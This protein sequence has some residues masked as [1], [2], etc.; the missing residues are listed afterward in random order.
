MPEKFDDEPPPSRY[1]AHNN[2]ENPPSREHKYSTADMKPENPWKRICCSILTC[3]VCIAIMIAISLLMQELF[4]PS[5]DEDWS[6]DAVNGTG[7][8]DLYVPGELTGTAA[9]LP[10]SMDFI[11]DVCSETRLG[12]DD[13]GACETACKP[14]GD[15]CNPFRSGNSTCF[16]DQPAGCFSYAKCHSLDGFLDPAHN[17][18]DR[19]CSKASIEI[20][21]EECE[22]A[23]SNVQCCFTPEE[24]CI[25][26]KFQACMDYAACQNL[27]E[28]SI[29]VAPTDLDSRCDKNAPT[30]ERD[31]KNA[32]C[33][34]DPNSDC[35]RDNFIACLSYSACN[36]AEDSG[37]TIRVAPIYS[38][39][40]PSPLVLADVCSIKGF[41]DYG[42]LKCLEACV[43]VQCCFAEGAASCFGDDP[44]GC[45]EYQR[46][47]ILKTPPY[48]ELTYPPS[49]HIVQPV[50]AAA[51][52]VAAST[53]ESAA[54]DNSTVVEAAEEEPQVE[55]GDSEVAEETI[56]PPQPA[57]PLNAPGR[58]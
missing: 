20:S 31:C 18:L 10:K 44:L 26:E 45:L 38:R 54:A 3:L 51:P 19:I 46:C 47:T 32:L 42:P 28:D 1:N 56:E 24:S 49:S 57:A 29:D 43:D 21:R 55:G 58:I 50:P 9:T 6:D 13:K 41:A 27:V 14:A 7:D 5:E 39:V 16:E 36:L 37:T 4:D 30:C 48:N 22:L 34:S 25:G 52:T 23:C 15:C 17:D 33:C 35:Y 2:K 11:E 40:K 8:D 53:E 12:R